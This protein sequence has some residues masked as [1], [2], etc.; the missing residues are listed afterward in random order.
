MTAPARHAADGPV[1]DVGWSSLLLVAGLLAGTVVL[2]DL[3][4]AVD[5]T[6][7]HVVLALVLALAL[8][9]VVRLVERW[10]GLSRVAA[11]VAVVTVLVGAVAA[12]VALLA[13]AVV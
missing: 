7:V 5:D 3:A 6:V 10:T 13:P 11:V 12:T 2:L 9:R 4:R 8:D 1:I